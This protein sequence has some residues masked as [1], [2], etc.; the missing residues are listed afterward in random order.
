MLRFEESLVKELME[1][2]DEDGTSHPY[3]DAVL[4]IAGRARQQARSRERWATAKGEECRRT[5]SFVCLLRD[6]RAVTCF[7][8]LCR[9]G[10][11]HVRQLCAHGAR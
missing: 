1:D 7:L 4:S 10:R 11:D 9:H 8:L 6:L 2:F 5:L 3:F